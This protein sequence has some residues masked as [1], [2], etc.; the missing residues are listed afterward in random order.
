M[1]QFILSAVI[2]VLSAMACQSSQEGSA[3]TSDADT[4][5]SIPALPVTLTLKWETDTLLTTCE[6]VIYDKDRDV[7]YVSNINGV[8][9]GKDG[10]G[11]ISK[12]S[13]D[14]KI[15]EVKWVKGMDAPKGM[16]I[17]NGK[18]YVTDIDRV[19][20][21]DLTNAKIIKTH[22][23]QDAKFL[24]DIAT[25]TTGRVYISDTG[26]NNILVIDNGKL[27]LWLDKLNGPNGLLVENNRLL[28]AQFSGQDLSTIDLTTKQVTQVADSVGMGDG[29]VAL[30]DGAYLVSGWNGI[31]SHVTSDWKSTVILDT[32][33]ESV[34]AADIEYIQNKKL[35]LVPAFFKNKVMAYELT[36]K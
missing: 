5:A 9:D 17:A 30:G 16:G 22:K 6:S 15:T 29:V 31:V 23:V 18:L 20:E 1:K 35:L 2:M 21:I 33:K 19:H 14:G 26:R 25:D 34:N 3:N 7:L 4:T 24:N 13:L 32:R 12:V 27:S 8:S 36:V 10:N 11:F 28:L